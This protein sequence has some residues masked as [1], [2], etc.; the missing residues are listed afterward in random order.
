M[1]PPSIVLLAAIVLALIV[2]A[3]AAYT[4]RLK[5]RYTRTYAELGEITGELIARLIKAAEREMSRRVGAAIKATIAVLDKDKKLSPR[6]ERKRSIDDLLFGDTP[7]TREK[8]FGAHSPSVSSFPWSPGDPIPDDCLEQVADLLR[9]V[10]GRKVVGDTHFPDA[11]PLDEILRAV[12]D[13]NATFV[14]GGDEVYGRF[15]DGGTS[16]NPA[17]ESGGGDFAA[18]VNTGGPKDETVRAS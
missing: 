15:H 16:L 9:K 4:I 3:Q 12:K 7:F 5:R 6:R 11:P 1:L 10:T 14:T 8:V 13:G 2:V 18:H 17:S